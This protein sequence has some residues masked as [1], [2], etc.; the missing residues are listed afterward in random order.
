MENILANVTTQINVLDKVTA[1]INAIDNRLERRFDKME[2]KFD[3][4][5]GMFEAMFEAKFSNFKEEVKQHE[6]RLIWRVL[7]VVSGVLIFAISYFLLL[8]VT[9]DLILSSSQLELVPYIYTN[10]IQTG[11]EESSLH[12]RVFPHKEDFS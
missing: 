6:V 3:K 2:A 8:R 7:F 9:K 1:Q 11:K 10:C 4:L 5:E 12:G